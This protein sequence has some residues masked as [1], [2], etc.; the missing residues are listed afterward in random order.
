MLEMN[1]IYYAFVWMFYCWATLGLL[2]GSELLESGPTL[3]CFTLAPLTIIIFTLKFI[4]SKG[5]ASCFDFVQIWLSEH[6]SN[7]FKFLMQFCFL[8]D[9]GDHILENICVLRHI[10][11]MNFQSWTVLGSQGC[12]EKKIQTAIS[13]LLLRP[14]FLCF[15]GQKIILNIFL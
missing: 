4:H 5:F 8:R 11:N 12:K 9:S 10:F 14:V 15:Q 7:K 1:G 3:S 13:M 6:K 2:H